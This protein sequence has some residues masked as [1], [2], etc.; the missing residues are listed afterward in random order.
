MIYDAARRKLGDNVL[1][2]FT[3]DHGSQFPFG[4]W[5]CTDAGLRTPLVAVWP[6]KIRAGTRSEALL[7][8]I[9]LLPTFIAASGGMPPSAGDQPGQLRGSSFLK[10]LLSEEEHHRSLVF[11]AHSSDGTMNEYPIRSVPARNWRYV[12]NLRPDAEHHTHVDKAASGD[13]RLYF[14]TWVR[15]AESDPAAAAIV[16][17]YHH[18]PAEELY[19]L[20]VDP[21]E[22]RNLA[23][24]PQ[25]AATLSQLRGE[26]DRWMQAQGDEGLKSEEQAKARLMKK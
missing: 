1:F 24:D 16:Q 21:W 17:H 10:V 3:A 7:S 13:G 8:W 12:R 11:A 23:A 4:K 9:D 14:D 19:D 22:Q 26:L 2:V 5:N 25:H 6:G 18:R 20:R 15:K